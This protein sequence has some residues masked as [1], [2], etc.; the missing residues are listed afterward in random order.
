LC[1]RVGQQIVL[2]RWNQVLTTDL[3]ELVHDPAQAF[4][5]HCDRIA[6]EA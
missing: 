4:I 1:R 2:A 5:E 3:V 6:E